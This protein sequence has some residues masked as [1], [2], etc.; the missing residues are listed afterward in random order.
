MAQAIKKK[1]AFQAK[2]I[3][4]YFSPEKTVEKSLT[5]TSKY[6]LGLHS[7]KRTY[8]PSNSRR[9]KVH[10]FLKRQAS[11]GGRNV[12]RRRR[13]KGRHILTVQVATK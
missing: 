5:R 11:S 2:D 10:G 6:G 12:L 9:L 1:N 4:F 7:M 8:Q 13:A 3:L